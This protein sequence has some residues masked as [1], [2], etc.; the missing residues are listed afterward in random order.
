[1]F[2]CCMTAHWEGW[3]FPAGHGS[4]RY[5]YDQWR[6]ALERYDSMIVDGL[7]EEIFVV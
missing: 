6:I 3:N 4:P 1:M 5:S 2:Q 7:T